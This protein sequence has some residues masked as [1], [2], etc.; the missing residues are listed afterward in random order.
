MKLKFQ[1][2]T[3]EVDKTMNNL[4]HAMSPRSIHKLGSL[5]AKTQIKNKYSRRWKLQTKKDSAWQRAKRMAH[6]GSGSGFPLGPS[7]GF[8][9]GTTYNSIRRGHGEA[10]GQVTL[11]GPYPQGSGVVTAELADP[12]FIRET[13]ENATHGLDRSVQMDH[14]QACFKWGTK[15]LEFRFWPGA[16]KYP[17]GGNIANMKYKS[18]AK[19]MFLDTEDIY[20]IRKDIHML[21]DHAAISNYAGMKQVYKDAGRVRPLPKARKEEELAPDSLP[22]APKV[23]QT[24]AEMNMELAALIRSQAYDD[25]EAGLNA[26]TYDEILDNIEDLHK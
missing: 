13:A 26:E 4:L 2:E 11:A 10:Y 1:L 25:T 22:K 15:G 6:E 14:I 5:R 9:T 8:L 24:K 16:P 12:E 23:I 20:L 21:L 7:Q 18:K 19:F 17:R 3:R